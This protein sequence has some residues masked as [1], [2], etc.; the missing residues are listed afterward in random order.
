MTLSC[1]LLSGAVTPSDPVLEIE[2]NGATVGFSGKNG[3]TSSKDKDDKSDTGS[4]KDE[5]D[6]LLVGFFEVVSSSSKL[7]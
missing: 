1:C 3:T 6:Q 2:G 5:K 4:K 7:E